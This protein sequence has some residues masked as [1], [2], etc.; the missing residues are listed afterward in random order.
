ME[1]K[2]TDLDLKSA[3]ML[4]YY[5]AAMWWSREQSYSPEQTSAFFTIIDTLFR[6]LGIYLSAILLVCIYLLGEKL[7]FA[8]Y[9]DSL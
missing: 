7:C 6:N 2:D 5:V 1:L 3:V 8:E 4:D 9:L